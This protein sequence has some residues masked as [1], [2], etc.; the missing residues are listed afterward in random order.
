MF[1]SYFHHKQWHL[2]YP[3]ASDLT[4]HTRKWT[5]E[6]E[7]FFLH[8]SSS[9]PLL[10]CSHKMY[11][12][13]VVV[14][15]VERTQWCTRLAKRNLTVGTTYTAAGP[16]FGPGHLEQRSRLDG[17]PPGSST[18]RPSWLHQSGKAVE[19]YCDEVSKPVD[20]ILPEG[21]GKD[22]RGRPSIGS[23][24]FLRALPRPP[25]NTP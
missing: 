22:R 24:L 17:A 23:F 13:S 14:L 8:S 20:S 12:I 16:F 2:R 19:N 10:S 4:N 25:L 11:V 1:L 5:Q 7:F 3:E 6:S 15:A 9:E 21:R 18:P